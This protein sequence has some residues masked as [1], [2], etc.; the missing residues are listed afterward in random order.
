MCFFSLVGKVVG[1][2]CAITGVLFIALPVPVIVSNFAYYYSKERNRQMTRAI[3]PK[4][5]VVAGS[6]ESLSVPSLICCSAVI[7]DDKRGPQF[8]NGKI[9]HDEEMFETSDSSTTNNNERAYCGRHTY[10]ESNV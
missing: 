8:K 3:E 2:F 5:E 9:A 1:C 10:I 7:P 4:Q 6:Q